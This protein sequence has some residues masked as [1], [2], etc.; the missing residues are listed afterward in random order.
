MSEV[1]KELGIPRTT[2]TSYIPLL[3]TVFL[4]YRLPA[5]VDGTSPRRS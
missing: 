3:E 5:L 4:V 2:L 1:S